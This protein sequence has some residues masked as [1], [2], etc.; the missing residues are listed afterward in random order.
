MIEMNFAQNLRQCDHDEIL[1]NISFM[2][3]QKCRTY[4]V[5]LLACP[6]VAVLR[7]RRRALRNSASTE[8]TL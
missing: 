1:L 5:F 4:N 7:T 2:E 6:L 8:K 3:K